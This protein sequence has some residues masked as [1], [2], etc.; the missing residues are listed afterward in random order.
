M[1]PR[2]DGLRQSTRGRLDGLKYAPGIREP[3]ALALS[4]SRNPGVRLPSPIETARLRDLKPSRRNARTH[5]NKQIG[6]IRNSM[7][8]FGWTYPI[9]IDENHEI[10]AG[11]G[12]YQAAKHL[13][14]RDVPVIVMTGLTKAEKRA[15]ALADNKIAANAGWDRAVLAA[16]LGELADLLP[17]CDLDI[18]IAGFEPAEIDS[19]MGDLVDP[20][21][22]PADEFPPSTEIP[23][24]RSGDLWQLKEHQLLCGDATA[25]ADLRRLM[26]RHRAAMVFTDPPYNLRISSLQGRGRIKHGEFAQASGEM[27]SDQ[28]ARFLRTSLG[29]AA[30]HSASGCIHYVFIDW[31]HIG[32]LLSAGSDVYSELKNIIVWAKTNAGQGSFYR[33]QHEF[34]CVYKFGDA[35]HT[36]NIEL[37]RHGRN[38]SNVW[39]YP[40]VNTF[41]SGRMDE[42]ALVGLPLCHDPKSGSAVPAELAHL[43]DRLSA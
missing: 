36:N 42:L 39:T 17:E 5:Q 28:F 22:D 24:S 10:I 8:R 1:R 9:L 15:L 33:S 25:A 12:R 43:S 18:E 14:L 4:G 29:L 3:E 13:G 30:K 27:S 2:A 16:E 19:L 40:G 11:F 7:L 23:V 37:G 32:E 20:E 35:A 6:Q 38:R 21:Q 34:I 26:E 41:R 31:R